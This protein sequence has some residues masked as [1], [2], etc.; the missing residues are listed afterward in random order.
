[1]RNTPSNIVR[2][3]IF[4]EKFGYTLPCI[5]K[6]GLVARSQGDVGLARQ[7]REWLGPPTD[8]GGGHRPEARATARSR[9]RLRAS[10]SICPMLF[11]ECRPTRRFRNSVSLFVKWLKKLM[12]PLQ[13]GL[14]S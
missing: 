11:S 13:R 6:E 14:Y 8:K 10:R 4:R 9:P 3:S 1:M 12:L 5:L 2:G 7:Y